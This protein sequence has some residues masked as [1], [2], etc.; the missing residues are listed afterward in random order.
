[1]LS[2]I[3]ILTHCILLGLTACATKQLLQSDQAQTIMSNVWQTGQHIVW[4]LDWP[5]APVGGP[6]TV[7]IWRVGGRYRFEILE[8]V[9][10]ALIGETLIFDGH[11]AWQFNRFAAEPPVMLASP[12]LSPVTDAFAVIDQLLATSA[13]TATQEAAQTIHG[14]A[15][16]I[17]LTFDNKDRL[18]LWR[19]EETQLPVRVIFSVGGKEAR[20]EA[21]DFEPLLDPPEGLFELGDGG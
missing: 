2:K 7:E 21:R 17:T 19:D 15:L 18:L 12:R 1:M 5:V 14:P 13:R 4:E 6:L 16:K 8:A 3:I 10:P 11:T 9:A 20:L